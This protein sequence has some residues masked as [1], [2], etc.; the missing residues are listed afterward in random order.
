V[1]YFSFILDLNPQKPE[2]YG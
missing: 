1:S 2:L